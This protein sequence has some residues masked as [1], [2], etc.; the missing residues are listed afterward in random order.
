MTAALRRFSLVILMITSAFGQASAHRPTFEVAS[1]KMHPP[2]SPFRPESQ[3]FT[4]S[5]D[6]IRAIHVTLR[7]CLQWAYQIV[8]VSEESYDIVAKAERPV[9]ETGSN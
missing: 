8:D 9:P 2:G 1:I 3:G 5:P 4:M 7:G 6:G